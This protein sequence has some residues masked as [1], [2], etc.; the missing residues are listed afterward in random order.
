[1]KS[2]FWKESLLG[3]AEQVL[4][5]KSA[6]SEARIMGVVNRP[7]AEK[8]L[9]ICAADMTG[10]RPASANGASNLVACPP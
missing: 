2:S 4:M 9:R 10:T 5:T 6:F 7:S 8:L 1:M 3:A